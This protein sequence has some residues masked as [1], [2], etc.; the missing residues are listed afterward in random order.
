LPS[1]GEIPGQKIPE[2]KIM[3]D[4]SELIEHTK[5]ELQHVHDDIEHVSRDIDELTAHLKN[6]DEHLHHLLDE[7]EKKEIR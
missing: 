2:G 1:A 4:H 3:S 5:N 6:L 7:A